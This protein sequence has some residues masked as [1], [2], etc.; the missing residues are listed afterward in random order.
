[1]CPDILQY[2]TTQEYGLS[3]GS[4]KGGAVYVNGHAKEPYLSMTTAPDIRALSQ[5]FS[6]RQHI[7]ICAVTLD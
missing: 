2:L 4:E 3:E 6:S 7:N 5:L 1:M